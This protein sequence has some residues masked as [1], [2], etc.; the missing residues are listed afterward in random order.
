MS[1]RYSLYIVCVHTHACL[2][3]CTHVSVHVYACL[4]D[5]C[6]CMCTCVCAHLCVHVC[7]RA[8][9]LLRINLKVAFG[10]SV[11]IIVL[12]LEQ[13]P[14]LF[15]AMTFVKNSSLLSCRL[16]HIM[17]EIQVKTSFWQ[18]YYVRTAFVESHQEAQI[19][20]APPLL[21]LILSL[22]WVWFLPALSLCR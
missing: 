18:N 13:S 12:D 10:S 6:L 14:C 4:A 8:C 17:S 2:H 7:V 21:K 5:A 15:I 9:I 22:V 1:S 16:S 3:M 19:W 20:A 11:S